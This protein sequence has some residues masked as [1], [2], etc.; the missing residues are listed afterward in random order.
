V[1]A[2][3]RLQTQLL[4]WNAGTVIVAVADL[5]STPAGVLVGSV[6][7]LLALGAFALS[8]RRVEITAQRP[9]RAWIRSY[10]LLI[11]FLVGSVIVGAV[12]AGAL[13]GQ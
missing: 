8:L 13:P 4:L 1:R 7:L 12:L 11:A 2:R 10:A 9:M 5:A 3:R 6:L